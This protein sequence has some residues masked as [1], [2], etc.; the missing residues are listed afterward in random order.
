MFYIACTR[1]NNETFQ[2]N[3]EYR[4]KNNIKVIYGSALKIRHTYKSDSII[5]VVEMNNDLNRIEGIGLIKNN[6][7][8]NTRHRIYEH[9]EY[10]RYIYQGNFWLNRDLLE[11][12]DS[13]III[14]FDNI[15]FKGKSHLKCRS[16]ITI[17]TEKLFTHWKDYK[18]DELKEKLKNVFLFYYKDY[19]DI[20][21]IS[22]LPEEIILEPEK[23]KEQEKLELIEIIPNNK[24]RRLV[25]LDKNIEK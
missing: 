4:L 25:N 12:L 23:E 6:L 16:G 18:L 8:Y 21:T 1:F 5:F 17:I 14:I 11:S 20:K 15:L 9:I 10:N 13:D 7:V 3:M 22:F 2:Q 19:Q 24:K